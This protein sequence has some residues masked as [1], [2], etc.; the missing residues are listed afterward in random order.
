[1]F[2]RAPNPIWYLPDLIGQP[3]NDEYYAFF[4]TNTLPYLP[5]NVYRDPQGLTVWT[6][7]VVEFYPNGTLPDNLYFDPNLVYRIEIRHGNSQSDPLIYE[8]NNFVPGAGGGSSGNSLAILG[9][10][11]EVSNSTF[12]EVYFT[13]TLASTQ[14]TMTITTAGITTLT[15]LVLSGDQNQIN[16]P[17]FALRINNNGWTES[18]LR[19]RFNHNGA[20]WANGAIT[21]SIT[22]RAQTVA[23]RVSLI[24]SPNPPGVPE[25]VASGL[26]GT[27]DYQVLQGAIDLPASV[28]NALST[29]AYVDMIIQLPPT[30][31]VD[32]SS[33]Q[34]IG[35][36]DPL[37]TNF[38]PA[39]DIPTYQQQSEERM[40]DHLFHIYRNELLK[41]PKRSLLVGWNF[42]LNPFQFNPT[43]LTLQTSQ[44][45]YVAD[46]TILHQE[47]GSQVLTGKNSVA[48]RS[49]FLVKANSAATTTRFALIQYLD[50][51]TIIPYWSYIVSSLVRSRIFTSHGTQVRLKARLIY[52]ASLP[53]AIS[54]TEP[55][56]SWPAAADPIFAA[57]WSSISPLNDPAYILP[58]AYEDGSPTASPFSY[59]A[60]SFNKFQLPESSNADMTLGIVIYTMDNMNSTA[61]SEDQIAFD[62]ISLI[63]SEFAAD[64]FPQTFDESLRECQFYY[65]KTYEV[66][67]LSGTITN[68]GEQQSSALIVTNT[69]V[70]SALHIQSF[71]G[72]FKQLKRAVPIVAFYSPI[73]AT[74]DKANIEIIQNATVRVS[75]DVTAS[76]TWSL[77]PA[78]TSTTGFQMLAL[79]TSSA[80][81]TWTNAAATPGDEGLMSYQYI[82]DARLGV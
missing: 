16:N 70:S 61:A 52:R 6:G 51:K 14:P 32:I 31:I 30:G 44:T 2:V 36:S 53:S 48:Q 21:M 27:G 81:I 8:V 34:A 26:L 24:Y 71:A 66:K 41:K 12:A 65:E 7:D 18:Y 55:I 60:F 15:Q 74:V 79:D 1:M 10:D 42:P 62:K 56:A 38:N 47:A 78:V 82:A 17:P 64:A 23:E 29:V 67:D 37:P 9:T 72:N 25:V 69:G 75:A 13:S 5:Q 40:I 73:N 22:A 77:N 68:Q 50:P 33:V 20:I 58:N 57:G 19:Q 35:Q 39:N 3:L 46:Q 43:A 11:N 76:S 54:A 63:P 59:P 49:N 4:L 80:A 45:A 28:N